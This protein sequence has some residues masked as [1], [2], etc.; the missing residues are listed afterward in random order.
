MP[1]SQDQHD[2]QE[3]MGGETAHQQEGDGVSLPEAACRALPL[4]IGVEATDELLALLSAAGMNAL[5]D[6]DEEPP[7][8]AIVE[9]DA[10]SPEEA[11][12]K[13]RAVLGDVPI[14]PA[15]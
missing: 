12:E 14:E 9:V 6:P 5:P 7:R 13:I 4:R 15:E 2:S 1:E 8:R 11:A 10:D 3:R